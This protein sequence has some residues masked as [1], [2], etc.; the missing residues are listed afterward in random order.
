MKPEKDMEQKLEQLAKAIDSRDAFVDDVMTRIKNSPVQHGKKTEKGNIVFRRILMKNT[1]KFT[2]AA[3]ILIAAILSL[4]MLNTTVTPVQA[5]QQIRKAMDNAV[6]MHFRADTTKI[7]GNRTEYWL[8]LELGIEASQSENGHISFTDIKKEETLIYDPNLNTLTLS[9]A[10][11]NNLFKANSASEFL[12]MIIETLNGN[13]HAET[14]IKQENHNIIH[15]ITIP[16]GNPPG[17]VGTEIWRLTADKKTHLLTRMELEGWDETGTFIKIADFEYDYPESG[18]M[19]I[20]ALGVP[21]AAVIVDKRPSDNVNTIIERYETAQKNEP[22]HYAALILYTRYENGNQIADEAT[23]IYRDGNLQRREQLSLTDNLIDAK[24]KGDV[25]L[26]EEMGDTFNSMLN[27]WHNPQRL[28]RRLAEMYDGEYLYTTYQYFNDARQCNEDTYDKNRR[29]HFQVQS[30]YRGWTGE[31]DFFRLDS[32]SP[33]ITL[34]ENDYSKQHELICLQKLDEIDGAAWHTYKTPSGR[35]YKKL[36]YLNPEKDYICCRVETYL[37]QDEHW[38]KVWKNAE[39]YLVKDPSPSLGFTQR[40]TR[41]IT[42]YG[43]TASGCW[44]P[45]EIQWRTETQRG[46]G[47]MEE[48]ISI[49]KIYLD[50][51]REIPV[52]IF[53]PEFFSNYLSE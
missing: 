42:Q 15:E 19:N 8:S 5:V 4:T 11:R 50:T 41:E 7:D 48:D 17:S 51:E 30:F 53:D 12:D 1:V 49:I 36:C 33:E 27:W 31:A 20:Y 45:A 44:Y 23:I 39:E 6:W 2:A 35:R 22:T 43:Q 40:E 21:K 9:V 38:Q 18:P 37:I 34:I 10:D 16:R 32:Q 28:G 26:L 3:V 29:K 47:Q 14:T 24:R 52:D 25:V 13:D 46:K